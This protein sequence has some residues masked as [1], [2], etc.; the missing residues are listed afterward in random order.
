MRVSG[1][2]EAFPGER[3]RAVGSYP[4]RRTSAASLTD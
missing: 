4:K 3:A 2:R 1:G